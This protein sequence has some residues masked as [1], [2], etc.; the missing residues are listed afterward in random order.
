MRE[1]FLKCI[2]SGLAVKF[3]KNGKITGFLIAAPE[4]M[5]FSDKL[6]GVEVIGGPR[7]RK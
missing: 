1:T 4:R 5:E 3:I 2:A 7:A 6:M